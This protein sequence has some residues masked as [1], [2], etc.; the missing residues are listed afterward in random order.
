MIDI[1][2]IV[3]GWNCSGRVRTCYTSLA[4][5]T[6]RNFKAIFISDA[7]TDKSS[8]ECLDLPKKDWLKVQV[9]IKNWGAA[10]NR[11]YA[12]KRHKPKDVVM[13]MGMDDYIKS[14]CLQKIAD[15]YK[16]GAWMTYGNWENQKGKINSMA[17]D[18][19]QNTHVKN[20]YRKVT[21][22]STA[23]NTFKRFLFDKIPRDDFKLDDKWIRSCTEAEVMYSCLEMCPAERIRIIREPIYVYNQFLYNGTIRTQGS[24]YKR[25]VLAKICARKP[26]D[27]IS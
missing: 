24:G 14:N 17:L 16:K 18:F 13:F 7:P 25:E 20:D 22:R 3:T 6:Y 23:P 15:E 5:Q 2:V 26:R 4:S 21:Y 27:V 10:H 12:I 1:F 9:N 11:Y 8:Y 19:E